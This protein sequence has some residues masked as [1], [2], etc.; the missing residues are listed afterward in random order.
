MK[1]LPLFETMGKILI[2]GISLMLVLTG[3][4]GLF[5][6]DFGSGGNVTVTVETGEAARTIRPTNVTISAFERIE[7]EFANASGA[8]KILTLEK[9]QTS[10]TTT[11]ETG[12]WSITARGYI[13]I[14]DREY[15][16]AWG[17]S[18]V[19]VA[20][21]NKTVTVPLQTG[22][23]DGKPGVFSYTVN[24]PETPDGADLAIN[25]LNDLYGYENSN[26]GRSADLVNYRAGS[27]ELSPGYYLVSLSARLSG[28]KIAIWNELVHIYSGQE[29]ALT[30]TFTADDFIDS[31]TVSG[32]VYGGELEGKKKKKAT[33]VAY[34]DANNLN[35]IASVEVPSFSKMTAAPYY[36]RGAWSINAPKSFVGKDL[37]FRI[38]ETLGNPEGTYY[39]DGDSVEVSEN[40]NTDVA[41][42]ASFIWNKWVNTDNDDELTFSKIGRA[43]V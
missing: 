8:V 1:K 38:E 23:F 36:Y 2:M 31:V 24:F 41:L 14:G 11:L 28:G 10:G 22:I 39:W 6:P 4:Q 13:Q 42:N 5:E 30:H 27:F 21:G 17:S 33:V 40:G 16:A 18:S 3:C 34:A 37:Y 20:S 7:L 12:T 35:R 19:T 9:G 26:T 29:T 43:H 15:E 25:P 32:S